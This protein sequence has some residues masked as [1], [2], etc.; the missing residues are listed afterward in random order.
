METSTR[1]GVTVAQSVPDTNNSLFAKVH[2]TPSMEA[3]E[4]LH[5]NVTEWHSSDTATSGVRIGKA[6][7]PA[8]RN[9]L[10]SFSVVQQINVPACN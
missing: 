1:S 4:I 10:S 6:K 5:V 3:F 9:D 8:Y 2:V 7:I